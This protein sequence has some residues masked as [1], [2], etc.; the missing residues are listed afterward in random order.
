MNALATPTGSSPQTDVI[1]K[2]LTELRREYEAGQAQL[3]ALEQRAREL[4]NTM[5]RIT[6]AITVLEEVIAER[7]AIGE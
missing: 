7:Q 1:E 4:K 3:S 2:R 5:L 6:G